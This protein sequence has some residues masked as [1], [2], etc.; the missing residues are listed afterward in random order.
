MIKNSIVVLKKLFLSMPAMAFYLLSLAIA[1]AVATFVEDAHGTTAAKGLIYNSWWFEAILLVLAI[2]LINNITTLHLLQKKKTAILLFHLAFIVMILGAAITRYFSFEGTLNIREGQSASTMISSN[3]YIT[4]SAKTKNDSITVQKQVLL[5]TQTPTDFSTTFSI[6]DRKIKVKS[7][8]FYDA[9]TPQIVTSAIGKPFLN[10]YFTKDGRRSSTL[11]KPN[12]KNTIGHLVLGLNTSEKV[13]GNFIIK[14]NIIHYVAT[15]TVTLATMGQDE[16]LQLTKGDTSQIRPGQYIAI[17]GYRLIPERFYPNGLLSF[18]PISNPKQ[19]ENN[20][21]GVSVLLEIE[22]TPYQILIPGGNDMTVPPV[23]INIDNIEMRIGFNSI[24]KELPF[25]IYLNDFIL[26]R[27]PGSFSP[28]SFKSKVSIIDTGKPSFDYD[29]YMNHVLEHDGYRFFQ[30]SYDTDEQ[31][32]ILAVNQDY[33]GTLISYIGY[34]LMTLGMLLSLVIGKG[35]FR[36]L[37][38]I[39]NSALVIILLLGSMSIKAEENRPPADVSEAFG[40]MWYLDNAGRVQPLNSFNRELL[41]KIYRKDS[42]QSYTA[43]DVVLSLVCYPKFWSKQN[44][45]AIKNSDIVTNYQFDNKYASFSDFFTTNGTYILNDELEKAY[46]TSP[47]KQSKY[48][49]DLILLDERIN[50]VNMA[51]KGLMLK[52]IP[53]PNTTSAPWTTYTTAGENYTGMDSLFATSSIPLIIESIRTNNKAQ[54]L[55]FIDGLTKFQEKH[56]AE[57]IPSDLKKRAELLY[58]KLD[59]FS[60]LAHYFNVLGL[61]LVTL[62]LLRIFIQQKW[63]KIPIRIGI[64]LYLIGVI[65]QT[66]GIIL[67]WYISGYIPL[68]NSYESMVFIGWVTLLVGTFMGFKN[69]F[70][71]AFGAVIGGFALLMAFITNLNPEITPLVP[72]LKSYWLN[73]HVTIMMLGYAFA[74]SCAF[75][76]FI[77]L[78]S[79]A[80]QNKNNLSR[81]SEQV[82]ELWRINRLSLIMGLY[83]L[84]IG[85]FLGGVWANES[86]GT[87]WSWDPK[88]SWAL[89]SILIYAF[90]AHI[91]HIPSLKGRAIF[92]LITTIAFSSILMTYLGVNYFLGGMHSYA[93]GDPVIISMWYIVPITILIIIATIAFVKEDKYSTKQQKL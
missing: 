54:A 28:S 42:Y 17:D 14:K 81:V 61:L 39:K 10:L 44:I 16:S 57:I 21:Q 89:I 5:S 22:G 74:A 52:L 26:D 6:D 7:T 1:I 38:K 65:L 86:W 60:N 41:R 78:I 84:T 37:W 15:D 83:F 19:D 72:V 87:Y 51:L 45:I 68:S 24:K 70:G 56:A 77:T 31:G 85:C 75:I 9:V 90:I 27:Y 25:D 23:E 2:N 64:S 13:N 58:Q 92:A 91:H 59:L 47:A 20:L 76:G 79:L 71:F 11:I 88:E 93:K 55:I 62:L 63:I 67:R 32:T 82:N 30:A 46:Q 18:A 53:V 4:V 69:T 29:I 73:I 40:E 36:T 48:E 49:R 12:K 3:K 80:L 50:I 43:N 35:T 8:H 66:F 33:W 34:G